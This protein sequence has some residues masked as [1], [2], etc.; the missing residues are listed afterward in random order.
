MSDDITQAVRD[1]EDHLF[2]RF[3]SMDTQNRP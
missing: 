3:A 2:A 1:A